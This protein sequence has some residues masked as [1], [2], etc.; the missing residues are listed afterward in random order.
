M[1]SLLL[2]SK[3]CMPTTFI[4]P[5]YRGFFLKGLNKPQVHIRISRVLLL[6]TQTP[7]LQNALGSVFAFS[8]SLPWKNLPFFPGMWRRSANCL[9]CLEPAYVSKSYQPL[10]PS[11]KKMLNKYALNH[12]TDIFNFNIFLSKKK[13]W[14]TNFMS[15]TKKK[16]KNMKQIFC[17][18][19]LKAL[20]SEM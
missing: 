4:L 12:D 15:R 20:E 16:K 18:F 1:P 19:V 6:L 14:F 10:D 9:P 13:K 8:F 17:F 5:Q 7:Y 11:T 3:V 2:I